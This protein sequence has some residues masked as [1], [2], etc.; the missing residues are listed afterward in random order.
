MF[1]ILINITPS[2][3]TRKIITNL[4]I[5]MPHNFFNLIKKITKMKVYSHRAEKFLSVKNSFGE[6]ED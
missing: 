5:D 6:Y 4:R 2:P 1:L 3:T